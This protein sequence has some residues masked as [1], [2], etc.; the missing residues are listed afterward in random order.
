[1][2]EKLVAEKSGVGM[3]TLSMPT[4]PATMTP[5][6]PV[7]ALTSVAMSIPP[8]LT[9]AVFASRSSPD[10]VLMSEPKRVCLEPGTCVDVCRSVPLSQVRVCRGVP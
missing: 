2:V 8:A 5:N 10:T 9:T 1:M 3:G 7:P 6:L 4:I